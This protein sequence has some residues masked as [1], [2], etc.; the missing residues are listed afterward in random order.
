MRG[1]IRKRGKR[2]WR[3]VFDLDRGPDGQRR[4]T[5]K[6]VRGTKK[7]AENELATML[8]Q[9]QHGGFAEPNRAKV[10]E[11]LER[12]LE[13]GTPGI[14]EKTRERYGE[15]CRNHVIPALGSRE[16][17]KLRPAEIQSFYHHAETSGRRDGRGGLSKRSV[18]HIHRVFRLALQ[19]AVKWHLLSVNPCVAVTPPSPEP[20]EIVSIN[21]NQTATLLARLE[22]STLYAPVLVL[23]TTGLRRGELLGLRWR[24]VDLDRATLAVTQSLEQTRDKLRFKTPKTKRSRRVITLPAITVETMRRHRADQA[25]LKLQLGL[26]RDDGALVFSTVDGSPRSPRAFSKEFKRAATRIGMPDLTL[27][28]LRHTHASHLLASGIHPKIAQ[29]RLGHSSIAITMD[30]YSHVTESMQR[31][32]ADV[33]DAFLRAAMNKRNENETP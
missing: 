1:S 24:D 21:E 26:G 5:T 17:Q 18:L 11:F 28:G 32:A 13:V 25:R 6:T 22:G 20:R 12:W 30:L 23:V 29:E 8:A 31:G 9:I 2:S 10:G 16:L 27:H 4:Q 19:Q 3:I 14:S 33:M 15:I 7:D